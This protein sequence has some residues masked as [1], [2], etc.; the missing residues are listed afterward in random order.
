LFSIIEW[1]VQVTVIPE[2]RRIIV[3]S[4]GIWNGLNGLIPIGGH[5]IPVSIVGDSLL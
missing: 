4:S 2:D 5:I 3:F 1:W